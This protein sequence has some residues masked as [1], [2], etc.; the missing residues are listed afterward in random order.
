MTPEERVDIA[1]ELTESIT[2]IMMDSIKY[3]NPGISDQELL[4]KARQRI[5]FGRRQ[6]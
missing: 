6:H 4:D 2:N 5:Q 3:E 1:L